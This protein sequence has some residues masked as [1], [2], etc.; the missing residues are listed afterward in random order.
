MTRRALPALLAACA[1][2]LLASCVRRSLSEE[3]TRRAVAE[4]LRAAVRADT[5]RFLARDTVRLRD[6]VRVTEERK[7]DT[8]YITRTRSVWRDREA[9]TASAA[10]RS[11]ADTIYIERRDTVTLTRAEAKTGGALAQ[12]PRRALRLSLLCGVSFLCALAAALLLRR[13]K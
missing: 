4:T 11:A 5:F 3:S 2:A 1:L 12:V 7:G 9:Q 8:V 13:R 6:T 10:S